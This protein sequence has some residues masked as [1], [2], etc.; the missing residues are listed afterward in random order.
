[1]ASTSRNRLAAV[2]LAASLAAPAQAVPFN[3]GA[4][5][6]QLDTQLT[7]QAAWSGARADRELIGVADGGRAPAASGDDGRLNFKRGETFSKRFSGWHGLELKSGASGAF[8]SGR[9]WYDFELE[10]EARPFAAIDDRGRAR[11]ARASGAELLEA[12]AYHN[13]ELGEQPGRLRLG[14]QGLHWGEGRLIPGGIDV[15]NPFDAAI[16][17]RPDAPLTEGRLPVNL[18]HAAQGLSDDWSLEAFYQLEWRPTTLDNCGS[19]LAPA[20]H[21]ADGCDRLARPLGASLPRGADREPGDGGQFGLALRYHHAPLAT[22]FGAYALHYHSRLP[23]LGLTADRYFLAY[24]EDIRLYG[25]SFASTLASGSLW[26]GE[27]SLRPDAPLQPAIGEGL[28]S[29]AVQPAWRR[30]AVS[31][32]QSSLEHHFDQ[33]MGASRLSLVGELAWLHVGGLHGRYGRDP[34]FGPGPQAGGGC[35]LAPGATTRY[36]ESEGFTTGDAWGYRLQ[37]LWEYPR[38]F[39]GIDLR[40]RLGWAHDVAGH[41]P[42]PEATFV[43]G[44]KALTL[45]LTAEYRGSYSA[46]LAYTDFFGGRYSTLGDRDYLSL[47]LG[48]RF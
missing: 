26:R 11:G 7:L 48:L 6:G 42:A 32:L 15:I 31:Q 3:L 30:H 10:D 34:L 43:E 44:R 12:F 38:A 47:A 13:H 8:V 46:S 40:P 33:V 14:R 37:A 20:D 9:Y 17:R 16:W 4:L 28:A 35:P 45:G 1:M 21:L 25:L 23:L 29:G 39:A 22:E 24:P 41:S 2:T 19:F 18:L 5:E 36:C 27:F